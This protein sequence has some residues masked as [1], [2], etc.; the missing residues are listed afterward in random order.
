MNSRI[1][2]VDEADVL[3]V[4]GSA[5]RSES[6]VLNARIRKAVVNNDLKV[7]V[8]GSTE[9]L[10]YDFT[11][12]GTTP[13]VLEDVLAG[14]HA[15]SKTLESAKTPMVLVGGHT[16]QRT[17]GKAILDTVQSICDKFG[18]IDPENHWNGFN[19]L[20]KDIGT[21]GALE[22]GIPATY[23]A[24]KKAKLVYLLGADNFKPDDIPEGAFV[25]YQ[26]THGDEGAQRA[27][28]VL[29][30]AAYT[31]K[32]GTYVNLDG[33]VVLTRLAVTPPGTA[34]NDWE[35]LRALSEVVGATLPYDNISEIRYRIAEIAPHLIKYDYV[36]PYNFV[37]KYVKGGKGGL[38]NT[39]LSD[40]VDNFYM[41]DAPSRASPTMAKC[42]QAFSAKKQTN[43][44]F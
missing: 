16:L 15:F 9:N 6:P 44:P 2:G 29:P 21:I 4:V 14:K 33:R 23:Q 19:V 42:T 18:V 24:E 39:V 12:L 32:G 26:G 20:N 34:R 28:L 17:D 1:T 5:L 8:I 7:Y 25:V 38:L 41:M 43:F 10:T 31:E 35:V 37:K 40:Y 36:E 30:G 3:L 27:D 13:K 11:H 22:V